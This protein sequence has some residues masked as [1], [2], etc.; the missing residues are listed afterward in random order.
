MGTVGTVRR[1]RPVAPLALLV[2]GLVAL[3]AV[4]AGPGIGG[5]VMEV[6]RSAVALDPDPG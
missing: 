6:Q 5:A 4:P 2:G 1:R 3:Q